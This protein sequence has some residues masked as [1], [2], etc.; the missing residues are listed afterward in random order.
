MLKVKHIHKVYKDTAR[1]LEVLKG[2]SFEVKEKDIVAVV[3][4]S[5][6]G[7]STLLHLLGALDKPTSGEIEFQGRSLNRLSEIEL[8]R[9]RN[10]RIGFIFQFYHLLNEFSVMEN[11]SLPALINSDKTRIEKKLI[12]DKAKNLL[13][14]VGLKDRLKHLPN[15]L[16]GGEMQRVA[17]AR[18]LINEPDLLLCD[19]P[20]CNLDSANGDKVCGILKKLNIENK[21]T[22]VVVTHD[23]DVA[24]LASKVI[25]IKDGL[26][27][28]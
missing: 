6:A 20:T 2:V 16:S 13:E 5:G 27:V 18:S 17:I 7:K 12:F 23:D 28:N 26:I 19:E 11:V 8:A 25:H 4:P 24:G 15:Q 10:T 22:I 9:L 14:M 1:D 21:T 3:G